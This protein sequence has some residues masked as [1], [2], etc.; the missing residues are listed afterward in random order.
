MEGRQTCRSA[1]IHQRGLR[2][3]FRLGSTEIRVSLLLFILPPVFLLAGWLKEYSI[4]FF[5]I[6]LHEICHIAT[7][8]IF[9]V[10]PSSVS[11]S[12]AGFSADIPDFKCSRKA[13]LLIYSAGPAANLLLFA[14]GLAAGLVFPGRGELTVL[15]S[16]T[17]LLLALFNLLPVFPLDGGRL[18]LIL[19][20]G[21][22]GLLAAGRTVRTTAWAISSAVVLYGIYQAYAGA[23]NI[24]LII[25]GAYMMLLLGNGRMESAFMNI[26]QILQ[27]R[28]RFLKKGVYP[29]RD[30][31]VVKGTLLADTIKNM[32]YDRFHIIYVLDDNMRLLKAFTENE[33]MDA[34]VG[35]SENITFG[36][37]ITK[38]EDGSQT[39]TGLGT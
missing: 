5:S 20:S 38:S 29:V 9:M 31:V 22:I 19:L 27:R 37:L 36:Q 35:S 6:M 8:R 11:I 2:L 12:P 15:L 18:L 32:D 14:A 21:N 16:A 30:L 34:L 1:G 10:L 33:I 24:S 3:R 13:L 26:K 28:S 25:A 39:N 7:A 23:L 4:A 17:N